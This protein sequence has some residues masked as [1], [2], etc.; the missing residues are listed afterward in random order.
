MVLVDS[1]VER[2]RQGFANT[3]EG[4]VVLG[5]THMPFDRLADRRRFVNPGSLGLPY[6]STGALWATLGPDVVLRRT[7]Y[8]VKAAVE[9]FRRRAADYPGLEELIAQNLLTVPS[10][11]EALA[12]FTEMAAGSPAGA[13]RD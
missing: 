11:A 10:D 7:A 2:Y 9:T 3:D 12:F 1:P 13:G 6:G 4:V 8:D 5:H